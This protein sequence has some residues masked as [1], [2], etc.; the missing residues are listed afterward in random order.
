MT[1]LGKQGLLDQR[2][3]IIDNYTG[4]R[5]TSAKELFP[6][7]IDNLCSTLEKKGSENLDKKRK[8]VI[9]A[10]FGLY[11]LMNRPANMEYV[12]GHACRAAKAENFNDIPPSR[13]DSLYNAFLK[14]QKDLEY[15]GRLVEGH[16]FE[17]KNYN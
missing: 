14:A 17:Q 5:T 10:I 12:K 1:L 2:D 7:E 4:G 9:A 11:K 6:E 15:T 13:L 8:R 16:F 3:V